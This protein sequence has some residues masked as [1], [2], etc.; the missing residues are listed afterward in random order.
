MTEKQAKALVALLSNPTREKA[1]AAAGIT[2]KT[3]R[4]YLQ[5][6]EFAEEYKKATSEMISEAADISKKTLS[7]AIGILYSIAKNAKENGQIRVS[8]CRSLLEFGLKLVEIHD[9]MQRLERLE[10]EADL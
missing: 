10:K 1:A 9:I 2:S 3:L 6:A 4:A 8:A 5:D 7:P